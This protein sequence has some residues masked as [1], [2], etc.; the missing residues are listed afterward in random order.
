[1]M[2]DIEDIKSVLSVNG[3]FPLS[4]VRIGE[5]LDQESRPFELFEAKLAI[6]KALHKD[7]GE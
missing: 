2:E 7:R 3:I 1:M 5:M 4:L 6:P